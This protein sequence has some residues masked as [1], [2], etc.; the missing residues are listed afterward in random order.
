[1]G[2]GTSAKTYTIAITGGSLAIANN[3]SYVTPETLG[4]VN[5]PIGYFTGTRAV[6]GNLTAYL[7]T[8]AG[9]TTNTLLNDLLAAP[10]ET[11]YYLEIQVGGSANA[12]K[13][14]LEMPAVT[15]QVPTIDV[16]DVISTTINF[17]AQGSV[18]P[19]SASADLADSS[20]TSYYDVEAANDILVRYYSA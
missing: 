12:V 8:G 7:K 13:V 3:V 20:S 2:G 17:A 15:L 5:K 4:V 9:N 11:K 14:E 6:S 16:Q 10:S 1:M 19:S 18:L